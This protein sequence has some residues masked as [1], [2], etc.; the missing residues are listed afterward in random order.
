[1]Y[2]VKL[3][4]GWK[5]RLVIDNRYYILCFLLSIITDALLLIFLVDYRLFYAFWLHAIDW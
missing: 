2:N 4:Q 1:M 3:I 5:Y